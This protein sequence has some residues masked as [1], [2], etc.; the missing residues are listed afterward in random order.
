MVQLF[1]TALEEPQGYE[2][3]VIQLLFQLWRHLYGLTET[4][5]K[6]MPAIPDGQPARIKAMLA[7]IHKNYSDSISVA[8]IGAS[9]NVSEREAYRTFRQVLGITPGAYLQQSRVDCASRLLTETNES[10]TDIGLSRGFSSPNYFCMAFKD[11]IGVSP[12][13]FR[14]RSTDI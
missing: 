9:A 2:L 6:E 1:Q 5:L 12:R 13:E 11:M 14:K 4:V 7:Y 10:V 3:Q 8:D